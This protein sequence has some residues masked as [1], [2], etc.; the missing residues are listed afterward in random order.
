MKVEFW[1]NVVSVK[2][3]YSGDDVGGLEL[4]SDYVEVL[5]ITMVASGA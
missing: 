2:W 3:G 5:E 4:D 1:L